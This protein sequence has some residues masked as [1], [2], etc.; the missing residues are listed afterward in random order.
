[1]DA[2]VLV[3]H[4]DD[5]NP[6]PER[7]ASELRVIYEPQLHGYIRRSVTLILRPD[8]TAIFYPFRTLA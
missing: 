8:P 2:I 5:F 4:P 7:R 6:K 1:M 3:N